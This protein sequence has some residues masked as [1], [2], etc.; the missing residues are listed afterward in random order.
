M[1]NLE[2]EMEK[3]RA[4]VGGG[5][6]KSADLRTEF[7]PLLDIQEQLFRGDMQD[8]FHHW[9]RYA[10]ALNGKARGRCFWAL[11]GFL[12]WIPI[13]TKIPNCGDQALERL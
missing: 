3:G 13:S 2:K 12:A 4:A 11:R 5:R 9:Q 8:G 7:V 6:Q 1:K 10:Y